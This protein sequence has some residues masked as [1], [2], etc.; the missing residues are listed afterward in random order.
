MIA[1]R[2]EAGVQSSLPLMRRVYMTLAGGFLVTAVMAYWGV[3]TPQWLSWL[4][5]HPF[6]ST[7]GLL[8][9]TLG[10]LFLMGA[11]Q[12]V[13]PLNVLAF[14]AFSSV[15]GLAMAPSLVRAEAHSPG[16]VMSALGLTMGLFVVLS[17]YTLLSRRDFSKW[18]A[19]LSTGLWCLIGGWILL[20]F[21]HVHGAALWLSV[22]GVF[23]FGGYIIYDTDRLRRDSDPGDYLLVA[24]SLYLDVLNVFLYILS[25]VSNDK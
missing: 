24:V 25:L 13:W 4:G 16:S 5:L 10:L 2:V 18:G 8:G 11:V 19:F 23:L 22:V 20:A 14:G 21:F 17:T 1:T 7:W 3:S 6:I 12:K 9:S 15:W